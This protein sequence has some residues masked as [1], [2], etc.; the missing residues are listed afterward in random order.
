IQYYKES[1]SSYKGIPP[2][3]N[4]PIMN[5]MTAYYKTTRRKSIVNIH[6]KLCNSSKIQRKWAKNKAKVK[7]HS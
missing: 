2:G 4:C 1:D 6:E 3:E 5:R 7:T